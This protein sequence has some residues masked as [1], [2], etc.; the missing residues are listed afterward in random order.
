MPRLRPPSSWPMIF[1]LLATIA[2]LFVCLIV[3]LTWRYS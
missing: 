3:F 2:V 1:V